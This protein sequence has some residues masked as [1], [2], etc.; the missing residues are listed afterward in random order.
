ML[1]LKPKERRHLGRQLRAER[2][3]VTV[4]LGTVSHLPELGLVCASVCIVPNDEPAEVLFE[5]MVGALHASR[6]VDD[7]NVVVVGA[8]GDSQL[9]RTQGELGRECRPAP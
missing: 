4:L 7:E 9:L 3:V 8:W 5:D 2:R 1:L 6:A